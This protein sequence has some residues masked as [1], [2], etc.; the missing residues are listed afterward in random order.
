MMEAKRF[1]RAPAEP[2]F[3]VMKNICRGDAIDKGGR[4][5]IRC[6]REAGGGGDGVRVNPTTKG[7]E[8]EMVADRGPN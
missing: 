1:N 4:W 7:P 6:S 8:R 2:C 5:E 3:E